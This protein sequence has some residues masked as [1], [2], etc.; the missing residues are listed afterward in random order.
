MSYEKP[1][2]QV[3]ADTAAFWEGCKRHQLLVQRCQRCH[4]YRF[5][6]GPTCP[7]CNSGD[8]TWTKV[9]GRG[10]VYS[11]I[12]VT[13]NIHPAFAGEV[14]YVVAVVELEEQ[15]GLRIPGNLIDCDAGAI[16]G[17]MPV[18]VVFEDV[19]PGVTLPKWRPLP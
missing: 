17:G 14:P 7:H 1:L 6:P 4:R 5:F 12:V 15:E 11:W 9:S 18:E 19:T 16:R 3:D 10:K 2:P 8:L 13:R